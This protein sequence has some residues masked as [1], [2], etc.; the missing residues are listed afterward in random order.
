VDSIHIGFLR[1]TPFREIR[2]RWWIFGFIFA[3][4][5]LSFIQRTSIA[6]AGDSIIAALPITQIQIGLLN[7]AF[8]TTYTLMQIPAG[9]LGERFGARLTFA[10]VGVL[11]FLATLAV[12]LVPI[13]FSGSG[14]FVALL[15]TQCVLGISQAPV[16][17]MGAALIEAWFPVNRWAIANGFQT[18]GMLLGG[19]VTP[20]LIV[21]LTQAVGWRAA[22]LSIAGPVLLVFA[23]WS[24]YGRNQPEDHPS[25]T[26]QE[27][28]ELPARPRGAAP[29]GSRRLTAILL[30]RDVLLLSLS[31]LC[32]NYTF[33]LLTFWSFLYLV[34]VRHFSGIT[35]GIAGMLPWIGGALGAAVGGVL[36]D[37]A[38]ERLGPRW[39]YRL[40]P[41][42]ALPIAGVLLL[43]TI[44]VSTP[45]AAVI[46]LGATFAAVE[47][48]E[49]AY[50]AATMRIARTDT[51][52]AAGVLN[53]GGNAGGI[54]CQPVVAWLSASGGWEAAFATG[55]VLA[56]IS[57]LLWIFVN[58]DPV[59]DSIL[60]PGT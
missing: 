24:W 4:A 6:V 55:A 41:M 20:V 59:A 45:W 28:D 47:V 36:S 17:P 50:W 54:L 51:G 48:N 46:A 40:V 3:F 57:A 56:F 8:L 1:V 14:V 32:M 26:R 58:T 7:A 35:S 39:G 49:G 23:V 44:S 11:G 37:R 34:Q 29:V 5:M 52:A 38:V 10:V 60:I 2:I 18:S 21:G 33:Y 19:A 53:T 30:D 42:I 25:V 31:Y 27:L 13:A 12:P 22:L 9:A 15:I 43:V 16:F